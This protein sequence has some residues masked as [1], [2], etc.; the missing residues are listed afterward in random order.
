MCKSIRRDL[1]NFLLRLA[2]YPQGRQVSFF[3]S[4]LCDSIRAHVQANKPATLTATIGLAR[5]YEAKNTSNRKHVTTSPRTIA[6]DAINEEVRQ[7]ESLQK[8][9]Q[10]VKDGEAVG[11]WSKSSPIFIGRE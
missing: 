8:L 11:P 10:L 2:R 3:I 7:D 4:G 9:V 1:K 6:S 5:L